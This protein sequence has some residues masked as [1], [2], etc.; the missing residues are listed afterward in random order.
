MSRFSIV[1]SV[2]VAAAIGGSL[3]AVTAPVYA[4]AE[5]APVVEAAPLAIGSP[6]PKLPVAEWVKGSPVTL[7]DG[8]VHVVEFWATWCGP[9]KTSIPHLTELAKKYAGKADFTGVSVWERGDDV[10]GKVKGFVNTM[11][12]QMDYHVARDDAK[13]TIAETW[14]KAANQNGIPTAFVVDKTGTVVW[15][16]HPM[17]GLDEAVGKVVAGTYDIKEAAA[18]YKTKQEAAAKEEAEGEAKNAKLT[19]LF[20]PALLLAKDKKYGE[21][22]AAMDKTLA[23]NPQY[24]KDVSF[25]KMNLL[26]MFD[27]ATAKAYVAKASPTLLKD[28]AQSLNSAAWGIVAPDS[29]AVKPDYPAALIMAQAA[30]KATGEKDPMILDTLSWAYEKND[31]IAEAIVAGT[32]AVALYPADSKDPDLL[33]MK[34]HLAALK[35]MK[36]GAK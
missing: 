27:A 34:A 22:V 2:A 36:P 32:K 10:P 26:M 21:A 16:G 28:S 25:V 4:Q 1:V 20:S 18:A 24:T 30:V 11:G 17:D 33:D 19:Q 9:C 31:K 15:I 5:T 12:A 29:K 13:G 7:G 8:K 3:T 23:A 6:A 14:M 35:A